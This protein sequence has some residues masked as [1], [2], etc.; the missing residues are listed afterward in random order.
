MILAKSGMAAIM[1]SLPV[2]YDAKFHRRLGESTSKCF[3]EFGRYT[4]AQLVGQNFRKGKR[5]QRA[6]SFPSVVIWTAESK[7]K[8]MDLPRKKKMFQ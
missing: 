8:L 3:L 2:T 6:D 1:L 5:D 7:R 4:S